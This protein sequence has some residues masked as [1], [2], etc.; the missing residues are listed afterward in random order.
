M[1]VGLIKDAKELAQSFQPL[2][3]ATITFADGAVLRVCTHGLRAADGTWQ[4]GGQDYLPR[5]LNQEVAALQALSEGGID[6]TP[7]VTLALNDADKFLWTNY[8]LAKGFAGAELKLT[9][10]QWNVGAN[11][12][13][14]DEIT[15]FVG[16][17]RS[18]PNRD[19]TTLSVTATSLLDFQR[20]QL[21]VVRVQRRCPWVFPA[22]AAE[23]LEGAEKEDSW[24]WECGYAPDHP[25]NPVGNFESGSTPYAKCNYTKTDCEARGMYKQDSAARATGRFGGVQW[26]PP[27]SWRSRPYGEQYVDGANTSNEA[28]FGQAVPLVYGTSW[29]SPVI[30]NTAGDGNTTGVEAIVCYGEVDD[31]EK[32]I[33]NDVEVPAATDMNHQ[34]K[35]VQDPN[36]AW[37]LINRG[38]RGGAPN[39][40]PRWDGKGDPYGSMCAIAVVVPRKLTDS[41]SV[42]RVQVLVRGPRLRRYT[43]PV[44]PAWDKVGAPQTVPF[45]GGG[46][47][48]NPAWVLMDTLVWLGYR[49]ELFDLQSWFDAAVFFDYA[50]GFKDQAG[51]SRV[52]PRFLASYALPEGGSGFESAAQVVRGLRNGARILLVPNSA[53]GGKLMAI[54]MSTLAQQQPAAVAGSNYNTP[55]ASKLATGSAANGYAAYRFDRSNI[56][57]RNGRSTL[58]LVGPAASGGELPNRVS[59]RFQDLHNNFSP[60]SIT[61]VD[62]EA[63]VRDGNQETPW[64]LAMRGVNNFDQA[65]RVTAAA[66]AAQRRGNPRNPPEGDPGGSY[67]WE[68]ETTFRAVHLWMGALC[69]LDEP[70]WGLANQVVRVMRITPGTNFETC[71]LVVAFHSDEWYLDTYGQEDAPRYSSS[72]RNREARPPYPLGGQV[73]AG[74]AF[75]DP[76]PMWGFER[77]F[78]MSTSRDENDKWHFR[79]RAVPPVNTFP[80]GLRPPFVPNEGSTA[81]TGGQLAGGRDYYVWLVALNGSG[82]VSPPSL[83]CRIAV[84]AGTSTNTITVPELDWDAGT[85]QYALFVGEGPLKPLYTGTVGGQPAQVTFGG[86]LN[87]QQASKPLPD[88]EFDVLRIKVK[89]VRNAGV[90]A[91]E[92]TGIT[93]PDKITCANAYWTVNQWAGYDCS[94]VGADM[95]L[96]I[97]PN[98][99]FR[100]VSNTS[101]T[102][103]IDVA[104]YAPAANVMSFGQGERYLLVMRTKPTAVTADTITEPNFDNSLNVE[105]PVYISGTS[106]ASPIVVT[107]AGHGY[108]TGNRVRIDYVTGNTAANGVWTITVVDANTF[109]LNGSAGNGAHAGGG[110]ARRF[111]GGLN[112][113]EAR[114]KLLRILTGKGR[115]H[116]YKIASN[117]ATT[118]TIEGTWVEAPDAT[119]RFITEEP[120][121]LKVVDTSP[122]NVAAWTPS[123]IPEYSVDL[124]GHSREALLCTLIP[125]DG[126]GNEAVEVASPVQDFFLWRDLGEPE[127]EF[128]SQINLVVQ[129]TLAIASDVASRISLNRGTPAVKVKAEVKQAPTGAGLSVKI[130]LGTADW[131][132]LTIAAGATSVTASATELAS[133]PAIPANQ[134]IRL[135]VTAVGTTFPG[136]DLSVSIYL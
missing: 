38:R 25:T 49:Y 44:A 22:T 37:Y 124:A 65:K 70:E 39:A 52:H 7:A 2:L 93:A 19:E 109:S 12:F 113:K 18:A 71:R 111:T 74:S 32:V 6:V 89:K 48:M 82:Q 103:T 85:A 106:N 96:D 21:P 95:G 67:W 130:L 10:V 30:A 41:A 88:P 135:D 92:V 87:L 81:P 24:F 110:T 14:I 131:L 15:K 66:L 45:T 53:N 126:G 116:V 98:W 118:L 132:T 94:I 20:M 112:A 5:I 119:S 43:D 99:S 91:A 79:V 90:F 134:N 73:S 97:C 51:R 76:D 129:G 29:V 123:L 104:S 107:A 122:V 120:E 9:F 13:S 77:F 26:D 84:P 114:G 105:G 55:I 59:F 72:R 61:V 56:I 3:L 100:V 36:F 35:K 57:R 127:T 23:R 33:V 34:S 17:I 11:D 31:I 64:S 58:H 83:P 27:A 46:G 75:L 102:L 8:E 68:F 16:R 86:P 80:A 108:A 125:V 133:A 60:D 54:A 28:K 40:L 47:N 69:V 78:G 42:P 121:W 115:G 4:Y 63:L 128:Q 117:T 1:P 50:I 101:D 62:R 136:A